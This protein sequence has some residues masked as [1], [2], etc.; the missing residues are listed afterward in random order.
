VPGAP[1]RFLLAFV[2]G[3]SLLQAGDYMRGEPNRWVV[4]NV[5]AAAFGGALAA[6]L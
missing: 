3:L 4:F 2:L 1:K 5:V 6:L